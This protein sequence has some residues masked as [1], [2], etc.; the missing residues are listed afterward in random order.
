VRI[1]AAAFIL[2]VFAVPAASAETCEGGKHRPLVSAKSTPLAPTA[3]EAIRENMT[4]W[5]IVAL[6]GPAA[7][8][9]GSGLTILEWDSTD[10]R[11][12]RVGGTSL[13]RA[14]LYAR[15]DKG[16]PSNKSL[17]RTRAR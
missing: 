4:L 13:C 11:E 3:F 9:V 16:V 14:P 2:L 12:F 10:G 15:F 6:L 1:F 5:E 7:R 8:D 17:E